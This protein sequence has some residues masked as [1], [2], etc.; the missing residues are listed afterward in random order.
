MQK[1]ESNTSSSSFSRSLISGVIFMALQ[2]K[3]EKFGFEEKTGFSILSQA[4]VRLF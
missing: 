1:Y 2:S 4:V 3:G